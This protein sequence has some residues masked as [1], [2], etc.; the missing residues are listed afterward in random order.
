MRRG[1]AA[2]A[3]FSR[4]AWAFLCSPLF[5]YN[6]YVPNLSLCRL[7][8]YPFLAIAMQCVTPCTVCCKTK[9]KT[10]LWRQREGGG[11]MPRR[12]PRR[13]L[14]FSHHARSR[15]AAAAPA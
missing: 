2:A 8:L 3:C 9:R 12:A 11:G 14:R 6:S 15:I 4:S 10:T 13:A 7:L 5:M 1:A